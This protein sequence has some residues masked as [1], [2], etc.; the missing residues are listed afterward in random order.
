MRG[1]KHYFR[2]TEEK[3]LSRKQKKSWRGIEQ[4]K[5]KYYCH[6]LPMVTYMVLIGL[7]EYIFEDGTSP[8]R[9]WFDELDPQAAALVTVAIGRLADGNI[10]NVKSIREG[11]AE[12][13]I[14]RGPGYRIY[15]G[16]DGKM[17]VIL[18]GGGTK[19]QQQRDIEAALQ[20]WRDYKV[21]KSGNRK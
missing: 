15:F 2:I 9:Q 4:N 8:F 20:C 13:R 18:L 6:T 21:R 7:A 10:S 14:D 19:R 11:M 17:L 16:W 5:N 3:Y 1:M 12:L